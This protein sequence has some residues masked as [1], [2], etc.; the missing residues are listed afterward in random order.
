MF[1]HHKTYK[2]IGKEKLNDLIEVCGACHSAIHEHENESGTHLWAATNK[3][4]RKTRKGLWS[5]P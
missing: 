2:R 3:V 4:V 1:I 5:G